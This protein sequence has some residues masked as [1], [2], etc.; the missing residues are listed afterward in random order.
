MEDTRYFPRVNPE[1]VGIH[2]VGIDNFLTAIEQEGIE[3]H[4]FMLIRHGKVA[5]EGWWHP[6][7]SEL[8][9]M[10]FSL[11]KSFTSTAI[12]LAVEEGILSVDAPIL[13]FFPTYLTPAIRENMDAV[14]IQHLLSMSTGHAEDTLPALYKDPDGDWVK[15]FLNCPITHEPGTHFLYNTGATYMLSAILQTVTGQTLLEFLTPRLFGPLGIHNPTWQTC[16]RGRSTGGFG[17]NVRTEDIAKFGVLYLNKGV[18]EGR[19]L[20]PVS[21]IEEAT[22]SHISNGDDPNNDWNQGYGYQFWRCRH[23]AYR[24]DGAFG[25]NCIVMPQQDAV[26]VNTAG[27]GQHPRI[28]QAVWDHLLPAMSDKSDLRGDSEAERLQQRLDALALSVPVDVH[29][30]HVSVTNIS[31]Q[32][33]DFTEDNQAELKRIK[34]TFSD[35]GFTVVA[36]QGSVQ[37]TLAGSYTDWLNNETSFFSPLENVTTASIA[38]GWMLPDCFVANICFTRTPFTEIVEAKFVDDGLHLTLRPRVG[39][40]TEANTFHLKG[41]R[42]SR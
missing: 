23:G 10:L 5:A 29:E 25:Q 35:H 11:S 4:S 2:P 32:W 33:F 7:A 1:A 19:Q 9:H 22:Q 24:G 39:F 40:D 16:P 8:P 3:L 26:F 18:W 6:Y 41:V 14:Q 42:A 12:G 27:T 31:G 15:A 20:V 34:F 21:W 13:S 36:E 28:L 37:H 30:A 38:G 17:L